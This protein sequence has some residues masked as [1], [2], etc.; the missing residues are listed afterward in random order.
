VPKDDGLGSL[1]GDLGDL[2]DIPG[3]GGSEKETKIVHDSNDSLEVSGLSVFEYIRVL[4]DAIIDKNLYSSNADFLNTYSS[5][6]FGY[7]AHIQSITATDILT[8]NLTALNISSS[9]LMTS[10]LQAI[11]GCINTLYVANEIC[12]N[13]EVINVLGNNVICEDF[14]SI[15]AQID[16]LSFNSISQL[17][18]LGNQLFNTIKKSSL[19]EILNVSISWQNVAAYRG[20]I[21]TINLYHDV[22]TESASG[23][24]RESISIDPYLL[25]MIYDAHSECRGDPTCFLS[26]SLTYD[27]ID[28]YSIKI[29]SICSLLTT[30][31]EK[32]NLFLEILMIPS[33]YGQIN[34]I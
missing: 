6:I 33:G 5:N 28:D 10:N 14:N 21:I 12:G 24:R 9:N 19:D 11:N 32:H 23:S 34:L 13:L 3:G 26:L 7:N 17:N 18:Y 1:A 16:N 20:N 4:N 8:S 15:N 2:F 27:F 31:I 22:S 30:D 29:N 25:E